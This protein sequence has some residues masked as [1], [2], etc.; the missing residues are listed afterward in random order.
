M[1][2]FLH[3]Y[4]HPDSRISNF[5]VF[6]YF[7]CILV[8]FYANVGISEVLISQI[9]TESWKKASI[10]STILKQPIFTSIINILLGKHTKYIK[11]EIKVD[12]RLKK[13]RSKNEDI[14]LFSV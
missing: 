6:I 1:V 5:I 2:I 14:Q 11:F 10:K 13:C 12:I 9:E 7:K 3:F 8:C 4:H